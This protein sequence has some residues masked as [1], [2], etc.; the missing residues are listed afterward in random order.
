MKVHANKIIGAVLTIAVSLIPSL[1]L[2]QEQP[3]AEQA[4]AVKQELPATAPDLA[5]I[6]PLAAKLTVRLADLENKIK[7]EPDISTFEKKYDGI[8]ADLD[9]FDGQLERLKDSKGYKYNKLVEIRQALDKENKSYE[10]ANTPLNQAIRQLGE[11]RSQWLAEKKRWNEWQS[12]LEKDGEF[13][14]LES[15]FEKANDTIDS[16]LDLVLSRLEAMLTVQERAGNLQERLSALSVELDALIQ[17]ERRSTLLDDI[18]AFVI[19]AIFF[20]IHKRRV[21]VRGD[22]RPG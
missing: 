4:P 5:N 16:A 17:D 8:E 18:S 13:D 6:V 2:T 15:T 1:G 9:D 7:A 21:M 12:S 19:R 10:A 11:W 3:Q 22:T 20:S 14:Q